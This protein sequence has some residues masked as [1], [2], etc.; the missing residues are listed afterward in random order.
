[1][2]ILRKMASDGSPEGLLSLVSMAGPVFFLEKEPDGKPKKGVEILSHE[3][4]NALASSFASDRVSDEC[5]V[6]VLTQ[7]LSKLLEQQTATSES[8]HFSSYKDF[9]PIM[10]EGLKSAKTTSTDASGPMMGL[11]N[12]LWKRVSSVLSHLLSPSSDRSKWKSGIPHA[13]ELIAIVDAVSENAPPAITSHLCV[14]FV[15]GSKNCLDAASALNSPSDHRVNEALELFAACVAGTC[16]I[17]QCDVAMQDVAK[18]V[19]SSAVSILSTSSSTDEA[20]DVQAAMKICEVLPKIK[21]KEDFVMN[22]FPALARLVSM[23]QPSLRKA[24]GGVL[25]TCR[26]N[27]VVLNARRQKEEAEKRAD[28]AER[29]VAE[30][31]RLLEQLEKEKDALEHTLA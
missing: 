27:E 8:K 26:V 6:L 7:L 31:E 22:I 30:L 1:M 5:K 12:G 23:E 2:D 15:S 18:E 29:R 21:E 13:S 19:L 17:Q 11:L 10:Q 9:V 4:T 25:A 20:V 3:A 24:A 14:L 16:R 28:R